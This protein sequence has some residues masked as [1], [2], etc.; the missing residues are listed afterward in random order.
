MSKVDEE[1][2][3]RRILLGNY[4]IGFLDGWKDQVG[5]ARHLAISSG[6]ILGEDTYNLGCEDG[7]SMKARVLASER[8]A[9]V[10]ED[11]PKSIGNIRPRSPYHEGYD[12]GRNGIV[13]SNNRMYWEASNLV[14]HLQAYED[15]FRRG[16]NEFDATLAREYEADFG[17]KNED[18]GIPMSEGPTNQISRKEY[19][20]ATGCLDYFPDALMEVAHCSLKGNQQHNPGS[21]LHWDRSKSTDEAD[22]LLRHL[23]ERGTIDTDGV[24]HSAKVAWRALAMLQKEIEAARGEQG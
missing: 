10:S 9:A 14:S 5:S 23:R 3:E 13:N 6:V 19:P 11:K 4:R 20:L 15:G 22:A 17:Q 7:I 1:M 12:D 2:A 21:P 16:E 8:K 24:R 18:E